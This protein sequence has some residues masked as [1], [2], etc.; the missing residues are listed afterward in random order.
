M[1]KY[2]GP[3]ISLKRSLPLGN[4]VCQNCGHRVSYVDFLPDEEYGNCALCNGF[5]I[6]TVIKKVDDGEV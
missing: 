2:R 5:M 1:S 6:V 4:G 3:D